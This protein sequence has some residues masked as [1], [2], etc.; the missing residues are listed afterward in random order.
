MA[1][2]ARL[3]FAGE[4]RDCAPVTAVLEI[5]PNQFSGEWCGENCFRIISVP[6]RDRLQSVSLRPRV[7]TSILDPTQAPIPTD[8]AATRLPRGH[9]A[10]HNRAHDIAM[11][12]EKVAPG[13]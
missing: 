4:Q 6:R 12:E 2:V 13:G 1:L 7:V 9:Q 8:N 10:V 11:A 3:L 5:T